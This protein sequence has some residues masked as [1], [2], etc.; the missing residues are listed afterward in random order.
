MNRLFLF[1]LASAFVFLTAMTTPVTAQPAPDETAGVDPAIARIMEAAAARNDGSLATVVGLAVETHPERVDAIRALAIALGGGDAVLAATQSPAPAPEVADPVAGAADARAFTP[2]DEP[3]VTAEREPRFLSLKGWEGDVELSANRNT[4]NTSQTSF[5]LSGVAAKEL[6]RWLHRFRG[7]AEFEENQEAT[8]KRRFLAGY[9][10]NYT[11][12]ER[13][14]VFGGLLYENDR[15]GGYDY[16]FS[17]TTGLGYQIIDREALQW[18]L[19]GGPGARHTKVEGEGLETEFVGVFASKFA[20]EIN[21]RTNLT[22]DFSM[23]VGS[24]RSSIDTTAA[25][26]MQINGA[27]SARLSYN[28]RFDTNLPTTASRTDTV[29]RVGLMYNF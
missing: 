16:R 2:E 23:F 7:R 11:F 18:S 25:I 24:D 8:T 26:R 3:D 19:E 21:G 14:Y 17:E 6:E 13:T 4:G 15:F 10:I 20:W 5:G 29:T 27:L 1:V 28:Y 12:S 22:H 9:D